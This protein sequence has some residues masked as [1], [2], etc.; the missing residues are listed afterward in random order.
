MMSRLKAMFGALLLLIIIIQFIRPARNN[1]GQAPIA[2]ISKQFN[3]AVE[4]QRILK[5]SCYDC[6]SNNTYYPWYTNIQPIGW[7]LANHIR[8]G[9]AELNFNEFGNYSRRRQ[10]SKLKA[11][12]NS[13]R[14][15]S[16]PLSSYT[17]VH[18]D[19]RLS[20]ETKAI[21]IEWVTSVRD[22][23]EKK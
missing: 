14:D 21:I 22:N 16:M 20:K 10:L 2:D 17:S 6:H 9:K 3:V 15:G 5:A 19:A 13:I 11:I 12:G 8:E 7:L 18:A 23:L 1:S 4:V